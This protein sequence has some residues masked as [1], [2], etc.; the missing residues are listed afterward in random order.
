[1]REN[2]KQLHSQYSEN[3][4][5]QTTMSFNEET[6]TEKISERK[7]MNKNGNSSLSGSHRHCSEYS[8]EAYAH[9]HTHTLTPLS[10][11][12]TVSIP[13]LGHI[14]TNT[15]GPLLALSRCMQFA[16]YHFSFNLLPIQSFAGQV[17]SMLN[18]FS[19]L[20]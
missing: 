5:N 1:V 3:T 2:E 10:S 4:E 11:S 9:S 19:L 6:Q 14:S 12:K 18:I 15:N 20:S 13:I 8:L 7:V 17:P 16:Q